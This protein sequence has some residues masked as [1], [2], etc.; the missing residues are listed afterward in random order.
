MLDYFPKNICNVDPNS[1]SLHP[2]KEIRYNRDK[3]R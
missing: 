1:I 2:I 3:D